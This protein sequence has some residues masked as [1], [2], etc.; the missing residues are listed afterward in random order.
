M[1]LVIVTEMFNFDRV[2]VYKFVILFSKNKTD[3]HTDD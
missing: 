3:S 2:P 1:R